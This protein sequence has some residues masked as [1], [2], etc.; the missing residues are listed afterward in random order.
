MICVVPMDVTE[1]LLLKIT[2]GKYIAVDFNPDLCFEKLN[3]ARWTS[4]MFNVFAHMRYATSSM[5]SPQVDKL[6]NSFECNQIT[7][8]HQNQIDHFLH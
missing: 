1:H 6:Q 8:K 2:P 3:E 7:R 5:A 4:I